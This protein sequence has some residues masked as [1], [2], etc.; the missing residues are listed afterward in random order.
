M[1]WAGE[2][3]P[4]PQNWFDLIRKLLLLPLPP[5]TKYQDFDLSA[6]ATAGGTEA[7]AASIKGPSLPLA[8]KPGIFKVLHACVWRNLDHHM[9]VF[10]VL[11]EGRRCALALM[12]GGST[13]GREFP[14]VLGHV[15]HHTVNNTMKEWKEHRCPV[16]MVA[17]ILAEPLDE[18]LVGWIQVC[19]EGEPTTCKNAVSSVTWRGR[20]TT[21][22]EKG[23]VCKMGV[24][25]REVESN[26]DFR[27][28]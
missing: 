1:G 24:G 10:C 25:T 7:T 13:D 17:W 5:N 22:V 2:I 19:R 14:L 12:F 6:T 20:L 23:H 9:S 15:Y 4:K 18:I 21:T 27:K 8:P 3:A 28:L 16:D 11:E 26:C